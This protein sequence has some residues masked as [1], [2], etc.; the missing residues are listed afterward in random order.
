MKIGDQA[1]DFELK[2]V[3]GSTVTLKDLKNGG[4]FCVI[5]SCNH[6]PYVLA[7]EDRI[8][9][10]ARTYSARG[11]KFV[12]VNANDP[13]KYPADSFDEMKKRAQMKDYP[14]HYLHDETQEAA[15]AFDAER[16]PEVFLFNTDGRLAYHGAPDDNYDDPKAVARP[17]LRD[18]LDALLNGKQPQ[19]Q[20]TQPQGCTIKWK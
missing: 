1:P 19:T 13:V 15:R 3:N 16:T 2:S 6:C 20:D 12:L 4:P 11:V 10:I 5:F 18:A 8:I 9:D 14:F 7:W 17:Y